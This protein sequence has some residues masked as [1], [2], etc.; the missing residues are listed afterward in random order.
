MVTDVCPSPQ[1]QQKALTLATAMEKNDCT[2]LVEWVKE[3]LKKV[4][5]I[6]GEGMS[7]M[8]EGMWDVPYGGGDGPPSSQ[9]YLNG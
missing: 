2:V 5:C 9:T 3:E 6:M 7:L 4:G 1:V 8:G